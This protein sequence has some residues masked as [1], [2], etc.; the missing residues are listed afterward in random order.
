MDG[1]RAPLGLPGP[2][3][4]AREFGGLGPAR[5]HPL[6]HVGEPR[7]GLDPVELLS[8]WQT[9]ARALR[10]RRRIAFNV[11]RPRALAAIVG[12]GW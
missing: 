1:R 9:G 6:E 7:L 4:Q 8:L 5:D 3:Q 11:A 2:G 10:V 12:V